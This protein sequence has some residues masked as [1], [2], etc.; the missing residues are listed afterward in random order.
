MK[1]VLILTLVLLSGCAVF[2]SG[3]DERI[4]AAVENIIEQERKDNLNINIPILEVYMIPCTKPKR[5]N[6]NSMGS[7]EVALRD[8]VVSFI[9]CNS[10][11]EELKGQIRL[12][13]ENKDAPT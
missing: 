6:D 8:A 5:P 4:T 9:E 1:Y 12:K 13:Q 2:S 3:P 10:K 7:Y 11:Y